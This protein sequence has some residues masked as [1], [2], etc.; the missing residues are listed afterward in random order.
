MMR[1]NRRELL[2][3]L[4]IAVTALVTW[5]H[6]KPGH[7]KGPPGSRPTTTTT[8]AATT[9]TIP[10]SGYSDVYEVAYA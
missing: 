9:T 6:H 3:Q 10:V 7:D 4:G 2:R 5:A 1:V 8:T